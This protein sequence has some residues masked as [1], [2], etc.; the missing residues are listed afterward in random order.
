MDPIILLGGSKH[1]PRRQELRDA[2]LKFHWLQGSSLFEA[3]FP[4]DLCKKGHWAPIAG[5]AY[6]IRTRAFTEAI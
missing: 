4:E 6:G 1:P 3:F 5:H 2:N